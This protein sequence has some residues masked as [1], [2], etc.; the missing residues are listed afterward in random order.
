[1][2][3]FCLTILVGV[4]QLIWVK[5]IHAQSSQAQ[6][7]QV[8]LMKLGSGKTWIYT[9]QNLQ[10]SGNFH[11]FL[12]R[13]EKHEI[14]NSKRLKTLKV[15]Q[16]K[17][18]L[19]GVQKLD[20]TIIESWDTTTSRWNVYY[21]FIYTYDALLNNTLSTSYNW[22]DTI[23]QWICDWKIESAFNANGNEIYSIGYEWD[24]TSRKWVQSYKLECTYDALGNIT[25]YAE[26]RWDF[27][28]S[29][30]INYHKDEYTYDANGKMTLRIHLCYYEKIESIFNVNGN[31]ILSFYYD[32]D[33][34]TSQ[35][36]F[37]SKFE[38][39]YDAYGNVNYSYFWDNTTSQWVVRGKA[40]YKHDANGNLTSFKSYSWS[41]ASNQ[42]V[43]GVNNE[44]TYDANGNNIFCFDYSWDS[45]TSQ[46]IVRSKFTSYYSEHNSGISEKHINVFPNPA[47][48][49][50]IFYIATIS[51]SATVEIFDI[52]GKKVFEQKL[53]VT[54]QI[55]ISHLCKGLY[56][57]KINNNGNIYTGKIIVN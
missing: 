52:L 26:Y 41:E 28:T 54:G 16:L 47:K 19:T 29:Q 24:K 18:S 9:Y 45:K 4:F 11:R 40:E 33:F 51:E 27:A 15:N 55:F 2:K 5:G 22:N 30:W 8:E 39:V 37:H 13:D 32:W 20:S 1:M 43:G 44:Y 17:S 6:L 50:I 56:L 49:S 12:T 14:Q 42:W 53:P 57:Y 38:I 48:E 7:N 23:G 46:W 10:D 35:W 25:R 34:D 31:N 3:T 36:V 21:K